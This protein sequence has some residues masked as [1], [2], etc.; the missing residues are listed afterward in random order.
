MNRTKQTWIDQK[1]PGQIGMDQDRPD[2]TKIDQNS[3]GYRPEQTWMNGG[4][5][6]SCGLL[7]LWILWIV[8]TWIAEQ[9]LELGRERAQLNKWSHL[10]LII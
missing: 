6:G 2:Q 10:L 4:D 9:M 5:C 3:F 7:I 1:G 8:F